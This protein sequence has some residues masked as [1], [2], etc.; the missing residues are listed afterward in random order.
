MSSDE[1]SYLDVLI[2]V[3]NKKR[4]ANINGLLLLLL[5]ITIILEVFIIIGIHSF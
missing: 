1:I 2:A 3:T 4:I 5:K